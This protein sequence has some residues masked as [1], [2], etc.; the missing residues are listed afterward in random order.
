MSY[1]CYLKGGLEQEN[2]FLKQKA[3]NICGKNYRVEKVSKL[4]FCN[5]AVIMD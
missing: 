4:L 5:T 3:S 1:N 2:I